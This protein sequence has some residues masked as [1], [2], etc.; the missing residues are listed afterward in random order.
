[1]PQSDMTGSIDGPPRLPEAKDFPATGPFSLAAPGPRFGARAIDLSL[2]LAPALVV[3]SLS[4]S[5]VAG[6]MQLDT[7]DWL[8][9]AIVGLGMA[10]E[11]VCVALFGRTV[12]KALL[13]LRVAR[14]T[15]GLRPNIAQ[16]AL[17]AIVP[18]SALALPLGPFAFGAFLVV[19]GTSL[20]GDL[21]RGVP[22]QAA[23]TIVISTR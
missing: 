19:Y 20:A 1:M 16:A 5:D 22:D 18:W 23:G 17:R 6:Q 14:Y 13:G 11:F 2:V 4:I 10:Y 7:P 9:A 15:D 8:L 12:G 3:I 21:H